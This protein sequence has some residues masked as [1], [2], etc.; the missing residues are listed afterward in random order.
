MSS[1]FSI[2]FVDELIVFECISFYFIRKGNKSTN[3]QIGANQYFFLSSFLSLFELL[4]ISNE[5][6]VCNGYLPDD[7]RLQRSYGTLLVLLLCVCLCLCDV[8]LL[9]FITFLLS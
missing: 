1:S 6:H 7:L 3:R 2:I 4:F 5:S 9:E 8:C